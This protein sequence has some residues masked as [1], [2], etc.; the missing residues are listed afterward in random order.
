MKQLFT[1]IILAVL[2]VPNSLYAETGQRLNVDGYN[3]HISATKLSNN[4]VVTGSIQGGEKCNNMMINIY[5][6]DENGS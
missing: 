3:L 1:L 5:L 4:L 2:F 6:V